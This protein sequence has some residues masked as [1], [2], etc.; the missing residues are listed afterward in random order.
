MS[1]LDFTVQEKDER[2]FSVRK[3]VAHFGV[4][5]PLTND[6]QARRPLSAPLASFSPL[7]IIRH[8]HV[9]SRVTKDHNQGSNL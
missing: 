5:R 4:N 9:S 8:N 3:I 6:K 2:P 1:L 7:I